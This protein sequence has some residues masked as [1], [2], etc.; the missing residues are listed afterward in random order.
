[1]QDLHFRLSQTTER[2]GWTELGYCCCRGTV[3]R[4]K[5]PPSF[6]IRRACTSV[7]HIKE[8]ETERVPMGRQR[9]SEEAMA[10]IVDLANPK[11]SWMTG[12]V[13]AVDGGLSI[14]EITRVTNRSTAR[15]CLIHRPESA[16]CVP[17]A[18]NERAI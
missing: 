6:M 4:L 16:P 1:M 5:R 14:A 3:R 12:Q 11:A 8:E 7:A 9:T 18:K 2:P 13:I 17:R 10:W 15:A